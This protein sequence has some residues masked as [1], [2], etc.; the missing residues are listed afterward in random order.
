M[1]F[2]RKL[3][4]VENIILR[5]IS[6]RVCVAHLVSY[7]FDRL[8]APCVSSYVGHENFKIITP[9]AWNKKLSRPCKIVWGYG[10]NQVKTTRH[11]LH[12]LAG[13]TKSCNSNITAGGGGKCVCAIKLIMV[14]YITTRA[15]DEE[16]A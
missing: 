10:V 15:S 12:R 1:S 4:I 3:F 14:R 11:L 9:P 6:S 8:P 16:P 7:I 2:S 13:Q 5:G